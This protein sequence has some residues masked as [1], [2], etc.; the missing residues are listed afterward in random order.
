MTKALLIII[1]IFIILVLILI[2]IIKKL[3]IIN[4]DYKNQADQ[5][6]RMFGEAN[7]KINK[8]TEEIEIEKNYK[9]E[10][11]KKLADV[12]CMSIDDVMHQ[13]QE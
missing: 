6:K 7:E 9:N 10:L 2:L 8:L 5:Y 1:G 13:L 12:A 3:K 4:K 11:A